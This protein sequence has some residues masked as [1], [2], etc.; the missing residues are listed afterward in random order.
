MKNLI[1]LIIGCAVLPLA[2]NA[3][4]T[5]SPTLEQR[6]RAIEDREAILKTMYSYAYLIDFGK[7]VHDYTDLYTDDAVFQN[8]LT[9]A[10][11]R[12]QR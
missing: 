9:A 12:D 8:N 5:A 10:P 4:S 3:Q 1:A 11:A 2:L 7:D 6:V